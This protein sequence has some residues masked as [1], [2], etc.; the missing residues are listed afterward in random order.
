[1]PNSLS[2]THPNSKQNLRSEDIFRHLISSVTD[3][4]IFVLDP[5]GNIA[6]WNSG[7]ELL[8]GYKA[9]EII[10]KH[11]SIFYTAPDLA[12]DK[13]G[14]ELRIA[15]EVGRFEDEG[16]RL[17]KDGS[18]FWASVVITR[19]LD[20]EGQ[21]LGFG[22]ITRDLTERRA[23]ELR[24]KL[25]IEGVLDYAIYFMDVNGNVGSWNLGAER[26]KGYRA[27]EIIGQHF[28]K[29]YS[30]DDRATGL[31]QQVL[32]TAEA[33]GHFEGEGWRY[34]K[35]GTRFWASVVV[36]PLRD[37]EGTL[38]GYCKITRD[39]T[40]RR[41]LLESLQ[42]HSE[43][44]ELQVREREQI[45]AELEAFAYSVSHDLR[46]P[47]RA[48]A[49]FADILKE[50]YGSQ[51]NA[52]AN[53]YLG[54]ITGAA[55]RMN[56]MIQDLMEYGRVARIDIPFA[57]IQLLSAVDRALV[58]IERPPDS[59]LQV[60]V[61]PDLTV[62]AHSV[63]LVQVIVNLLSNAFKFSQPEGHC[64]VCVTAEADDKHVR[65]SVRDNGIGIA[66]QYR[67][68]IWNVFERLHDRDTFAGSGIGLAIVKRAVA[69]MNGSCG[70]ESEVGQGSTFWVQ[71]ERV[72]TKGE[73]NE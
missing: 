16:W 38:Y 47:L 40:E 26:L 15:S 68:R 3:Y 4:A 63:V 21:L 1:M 46:A 25:L 36:T 28:S 57:P 22:K 5:K 72:A 24:H 19:L 41:K 7:A 39:L 42:Q 17:R 71:L 34:R 61:A 55:A 14:Y 8:K 52:E 50:D 10:G 59:T 44:L 62:C 30:V 73:G 29:F 6:S 12:I 18:R 32:K 2:S 51:L 64:E 43:E 13:P 60:E 31:P 53:D 54:E 9:D 20:D 48:I 49:G 65:L 45:N 23:S 27:D 67:E 56:S 37:E 35:D 58:Q 70:L 66:P 33:E 69:R 11:L